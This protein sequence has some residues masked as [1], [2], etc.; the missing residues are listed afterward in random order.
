METR[1][2]KKKT[3]RLPAWLWGI[4]AAAAFGIWHFPE[5]SAGAGECGDG[6]LP[7]WY[8]ILLLAVLAVLALT[9]WLFFVKKAEMSVLAPVCALCLGVLYLCVLAPLSAPDEVSHFISAYRLSNVL[10]GQPAADEE[11]RVYIRR[12]DGFLLDMDLE[13]GQSLEEREKEEDTRVLGQTLTEETYRVIY[14]TGISGTGETDMI[15]TAKPPVETTPLA[16]LPQALGIVLGRLLGLGGL[17]LLYLGRLGNLLFYAAALRYGVKRLPFGKE[18]MLGVGLLPMTLHL[19]AS[20][21]YDAMILAMSFLLTSVTFSLAF[22]AGEVRKRD[23]A[24]LAAIM[25]VLGPC[26]MIYGVLMGLCL[27]IPVK[28]FGGVK[29]WLLSAAAVAAVYGIA[30]ILVNSRIIAGYAGETEA[31]VGWAEEA[32]YSLGWVLHNPVGTLRLLYNTVL[33]RGEFFHLTMMGNWMSNLDPVLDVP[34]LLIWAMTFVL[35]FLS[36]KKPGE[37]TVYFSGRQRL[38]TAFLCLACAG[39]AMLSMLIAWTPMSSRWIMGVQG[40]YFLPFLPALLMILKNEWIL[41]K[42]NRDRGLLYFMVWANGYALLRL[43]S[44]VSMRI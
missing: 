5:V 40:R 39:A 15:V 20:F 28:K 34:Y 27:L 10:M 2:N 26:K 42:K 14:R 38:W 16:Y 12:Q 29:K 41:L 8:G 9:G 22:G 24:L 23:V 13:P 17:A 36:M 33:M 21:S 1:D 7:E 35:F 32:G 19:T 6:F 44:I 31:Y 43:F 3:V 30:M 25:G 37:E 4:P 11:G 18:I